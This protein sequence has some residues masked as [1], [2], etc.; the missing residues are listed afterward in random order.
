MLRDM[1]PLTALPHDATVL[2]ASPLDSSSPPDL[3]APT[4]NNS[5]ADVF[6]D[7]PPQS[8]TGD[9]TNRDGHPSEPSEIPRLR[10]THSTNGYRDGIGAS[11]A[12]YVQEG[13]DEGY[14]L[15][16]VLGLRVGYV[17]GVLK[18]LSAAVRSSES[19]VERMGRML[20]DARRE[21]RTESV[22]GREYFSED[23]N[24]TFDVGGQNKEGR[25]DEAAVAEEEG[26]ITFEHVAD[27]HPLLQRW[28]DVARREARR[29]SIDLRVWER[30]DED[31]D[32]DE[33]EREKVD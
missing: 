16:A 17:L 25:R 2:I 6:S 10:S 19:Q 5:T 26:D 24:W 23:G 1:P 33:G 8:P 29:L 3:V 21:L 31:E 18:G 22:F 7:T 32:E 13:F 9:A 4:T 12:Q 27:E 20:G 11:K 15:G 28:E 30:D 14:S